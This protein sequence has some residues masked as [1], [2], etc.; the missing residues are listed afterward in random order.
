MPEEEHPT[1]HN[2]GQAPAD[3]HEKPKKFVAKLAQRSLAL[4]MVAG[5]LGGGVYLLPKA[6]GSRRQQRQCPRCRTRRLSLLI[7]LRWPHRQF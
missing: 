1:D 5:I 7:P 4:G 2:Q 3:A 6:I